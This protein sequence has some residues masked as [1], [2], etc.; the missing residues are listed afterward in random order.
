MLLTD[1]EYNTVVVAWEAMAQQG[2]GDNGGG[3]G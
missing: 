2:G 1:L 3:C